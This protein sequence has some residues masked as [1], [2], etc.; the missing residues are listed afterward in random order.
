M[1]GNGPLWTLSD[2]WVRGRQPTVWAHSLGRFVGPISVPWRWAPLLL[3]RGWARILLSIISRSKGEHLTRCGG[4]SEPIITELFVG[5]PLVLQTGASFASEW[6][7]DNFV[8][9]SYSK[10]GRNPKCCEVRG[11]FPRERLLVSQAWR[12]ESRE[13]SPLVQISFLHLGVSWPS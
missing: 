6:W 3:M 11:S 10:R 2:S 8:A 9:A 7:D 5:G 13:T 4:G 1:A 12:R